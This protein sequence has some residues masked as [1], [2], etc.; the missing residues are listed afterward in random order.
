M[1]VAV[2]QPGREPAARA[3]DHLAGVL[4]RQLGG[5]AEPGDPAVLDRERAVSIAP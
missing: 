5:S 3:V 1:G 4:V 2:D